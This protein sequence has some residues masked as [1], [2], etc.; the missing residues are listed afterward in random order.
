MAEIIRIN[1]HEV[2]LDIAEELYE[3]S[4]D[5]ERWSSD[6]LIASSPFREDNSPSFFVTLEGEYA[7]TWG[8]S[9]AYDEEYSSG[10]F[11]SLIA[12]L[13]R[14]SYEEAADYLL[15][16]YG[17]LHAIR[18]NEP[19]R[20]KHPHIRTI[21]QTT[22]IEDSPI[23]VAPSPYLISRGISEYVQAEVG[24]GYDKEH[25]GYTAIPW[26]TEGGKDANI[27]YRSTQ[28]KRFFYRKD[29]TPKNRLVFGID[30]AGEFAVMTE[31]VID[32]M[33][34][35]TAG[36]SGVAV[37]GAR[38]S[39]FQAE[40]IKRSGIKR[41][42]LGGDNDEQGRALNEQ[43]KKKLRGY[44]EL[45][46]IDYGKEKDANDVLLR[47]GAGGL[48]EIMYKSV[49]IKSINLGARFRQHLR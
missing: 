43:A 7:G 31:G 27:F 26:R 21:F 10:N 18:K 49:S 48:R 34:F 33:S 41:L 45:Y 37:G 25:R 13:R 20:L 28:G 17:A 2:Q 46:E 5:N 16:K 3:Y 8:D 29:S 30:R 6:K 12:K 14:I 35:D 32:A 40:I 38:I 15:E 23:I 39:D 9:G 22:I 24:V 47:Q 44:V 42:Y 36:I 4:F 11:V 19:I 1:G